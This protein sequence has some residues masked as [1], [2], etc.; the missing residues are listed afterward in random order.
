VTATSAFSDLKVFCELMIAVNVLSS[1][2]VLYFI[3]FPILPHAVSGLQ[4]TSPFNGNKVTGVLG[5]SINFTWAFHGGNIDRVVWGTKQ[6]GAVS[7]KDVLVSVDKL[8]TITTIQHSPYSG[9]VSGDWDGSSPGQATFT[10]NS[11][12]K[13]DER[14]YSCQLSPES[15][16]VQA[17]Q[18]TVQLLVVGFTFAYPPTGP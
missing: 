14:F 4:F 5:S 3:L 10:L 17:V 7:I 15:L 11:I 6:D 2:Y 8:Q 1:S 13:A 12:Q 9:R 18:D 16:R